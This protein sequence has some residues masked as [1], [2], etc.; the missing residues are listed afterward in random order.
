MTDTTLNDSDLKFL[1][2]AGDTAITVDESLFEVINSDLEPN[3]LTW[4]RSLNY[5]PPIKLFIFSVDVKFRSLKQRKIP[6][7]EFYEFE[8]VIQEPTQIDKIR[9]L[10]YRK[11]E[12]PLK[13]IFLWHLYSLLTC[14]CSES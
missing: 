14:Y 13:L 10:V 9:F 1:A 2:A 3:F 5:L 7:T 12:N 4:A 6:T 8:S 11:L